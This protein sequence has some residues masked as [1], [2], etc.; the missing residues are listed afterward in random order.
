[1]S[2]VPGSKAPEFLLT[3][4]SFPLDAFWYVDSHYH[5]SHDSSEN[6]IAPP[7]VSVADLGQTEEFLPLGTTPV[8]PFR[9]SFFVSVICRLLDDALPLGEHDLMHG[10]L[11]AGKE[12]LSRQA[13][14]RGRSSNCRQFV[15]EHFKLV[16]V[17]SVV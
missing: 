4:S 5:S 10:P 7:A 17:G 3:L 13:A 6:M 12:L 2:T 9:H 11:L 8:F 16:N 1:M 14:E 15:E